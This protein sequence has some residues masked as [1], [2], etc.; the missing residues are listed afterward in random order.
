MSF[1]SCWVE[2]PGG[3]RGH[4]AHTYPL[5]WR[6]KNS[7]WHSKLLVPNLYPTWLATLK[8]DDCVEEIAYAS[9]YFCRLNEVP[10]EM[11]IPPFAL[12]KLQRQYVTGIED[13][14]NCSSFWKRGSCF[15]LTSW[16]FCVGAEGCKQGS[17]LTELHCR[18][19][20][21]HIAFWKPF[22]DLTVCCLHN[23][24]FDIAKLVAKSLPVNLIVWNAGCMKR[25]SEDMPS[26]SLGQAKF[27]V[28]KIA[29]AT[30]TADVCTADKQHWW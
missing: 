16:W 20:C 25:L 28:L 10:K 22:P 7:I 21:E 18:D 23:S 2:N 24:S 27:S 17:V 5:L 15:L 29:V 26:K 9:V 11:P 8:R 1:S 14:G 19:P 6:R 3:A 4:A 30:R 13:Q 12:K